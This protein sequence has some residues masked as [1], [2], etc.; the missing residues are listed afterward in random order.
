MDRNNLD[1][2]GTFKAKDH[3][4]EKK[5][6]L[7]NEDDSIDGLDYIVRCFKCGELGHKRSDCPEE[8]EVDLL[9]CHSDSLSD[10][11]LTSNSGELTEKQKQD[12]I[13]LAESFLPTFLKQKKAKNQ[14]EDDLS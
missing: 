7:T 13:L 2:G 6:S 5:M 1:D 12:M 4:Q 3:Q 14:G 8:D 11:D 10:D 9:I